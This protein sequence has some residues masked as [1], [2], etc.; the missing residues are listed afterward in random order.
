MQEIP[1]SAIPLLTLYCIRTPHS[2]AHR[3]VFVIA[4]GCKRSAWTLTGNWF[5]YRPAIQW[6]LHS[7]WK[8]G[9]GPVC[10]HWRKILRYCYVKKVMNRL[11]NLVPI[12]WKKKGQIYILKHIKM[13]TENQKGYSR[14]N[15]GKGQN[16]WHEKEAILLHRLLL[17]FYFY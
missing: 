17:Y 11:D 2:H 6:N 12:L 3:F 8:D 15:S 1:Y 4:E 10:A 16:F 13:N 7:H 9:G 14:F 5:N